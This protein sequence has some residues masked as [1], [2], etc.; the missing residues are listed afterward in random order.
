MEELLSKLQTILQSDEGQQQLG[1]LLSSLGM[2]NQAPA[3]PQAAGDATLQ[4]LLPLAGL[5]S[6]ANQN[7]DDNIRFL[8]ALR[9]ILSE[10][11]QQKADRAIQI[12]RMLSL[13]PLIRESG[14]LEGW[15]DHGESDTNL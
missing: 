14:L 15:F 11:R 9:P 4:K 5:L 7:S 3:Q 10:K 8:Q 12:L 1:G 2:T 13:L 6:Q